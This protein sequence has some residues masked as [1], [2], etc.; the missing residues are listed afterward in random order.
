MQGIVGV[1]LRVCI[2][3]TAAQAA[4]AKYNVRS[5]VNFRASNGKGQ[6]NDYMTGH[7]VRAFRASTLIC[8]RYTPFPTRR[9]PLWLS[10]EC[11][12][13]VCTMYACSY[14]LEIWTRYYKYN[15]WPHTC[16]CR[17]RLFQAVI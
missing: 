16:T 5:T 8:V 12:R 1:S 3:T 17:L 9:S 4:T 14:I 11:L 13:L 10:N 7:F 2:H 6:S 15:Q